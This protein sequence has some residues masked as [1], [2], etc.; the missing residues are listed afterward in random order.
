MRDFLARRG[1][2]LVYLAGGVLS[3]LVDIGVMQLLIAGGSAYQ[4]ATSLGFASG[5]LLNFAYHARLTFRAS[6]NS[7]NFARYMCV[8]AVNYGLTMAC[9]ALAVAWIT[10]PVQTSALIGKIFSL[11]IIAVNGF[12]LSK[13]WIFK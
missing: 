8:V 1:Q 3:A 9:V 5:L 13:Y 7:S 2:F 11:P 4:L 10:L 12:V 6:A